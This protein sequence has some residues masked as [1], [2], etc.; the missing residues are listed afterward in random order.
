MRGRGRSRSIRSGKTTSPLTRGSG[1]ITPAPMKLRGSPKP[2]A[3]THRSTWRRSAESI[4]PSGGGPRSG[5][6]ATSRPTYSTPPT[7]GWSWPTS[8][9]P[10][11]PASSA[12]PT[13]S[14]ASARPDTRR[15]IQKRG[16]ACHRKSFSPGSIRRWRTS[17][18]VSTTRLRAGP[19]G[20][21][22]VAGM[23]QNPGPAPGHHDRH[24]RLRRALR[25]GW[26]RC[27]HR[28]AGQDHWHLD[29][30]LRHRTVDDK[31]R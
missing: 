16:A 31:G 4:P 22:T 21:H 18:T 15:C 20:R 11:S 28:H 6:A 14:A 10:C 9:P 8:S 12:P 19:P 23:G 30:R 3:R 7:A 26:L 27:H 29:V 1:R 5:T 25:R 17:G 13:S 2:P 24:G